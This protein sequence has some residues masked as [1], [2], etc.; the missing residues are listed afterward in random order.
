MGPL[1]F[2]LWFPSLPRPT[3]VSASWPKRKDPTPYSISGV[4]ALP[5]HRVGFQHW[6]WTD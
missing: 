1:W 2:L 6:H 5:S 4:Q 3:L